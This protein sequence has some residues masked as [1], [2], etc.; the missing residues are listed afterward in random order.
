MSLTDQLTLTLCN[1][2]W[3]G[4]DSAQPVPIIAKAIRESAMTN[5]LLAPWNAH[6]GIP[7]FEQ[8]EAAHFKPAFEAALAENRAEINAIA[9]S[10][11]SATFEN[12]IAELELSG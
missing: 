8:I 10:A 6:F 1:A 3:T 5:P 7:P 2:A 9:D 11:E 12:T 4:W